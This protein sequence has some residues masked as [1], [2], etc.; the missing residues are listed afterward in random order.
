MKKNKDEKSIVRSVG[1]KP[2][3][4][5]NKKISRATKKLKS[6]K[7]IGILEKYLLNMLPA[8]TA[9]EWDQTG[10]LLGNPEDKIEKIAVCLDPTVQVV[11]FAA[12]QG[13]NLLLTHHPA[14][15][16][17]VT[18]FLPGNSVAN[19]NGALIYEA[20][21]N[22][23]A[24]MNFHTALD[25]SEQGAAVLPKLLNLQIKKVLCPTDEQIQSKSKLGFGR[26][27]VPKV[28]EKGIT[29]KQLAARC[30][31]VFGRAPKV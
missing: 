16:K 10:L 13:C 24:L 17:G 31:S 26:V 21:K 20:V 14:Y 19:H 2:S 15:I 12:S 28:S 11:K 9:C 6:K 8:E 29:L 4:P 3:R 27:C 30:K 25:V 18:D 7:T 5:V 23:V 1:N 22:N